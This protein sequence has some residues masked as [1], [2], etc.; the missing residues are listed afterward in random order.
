MCHVDGFDHFSFR[1]FIG[2]G[3]DHDDLF[4]GGRHC[5]VQIA[6]LP[7]LLGR[8]ENEF[9]VNQA[10][11]C[12]CAGSGKRNVGN[13]GCDSGT[14]HSH[15]LGA[16]GR[17]YGK[18]QV[19]Q[20]YIISVILREQRAHGTV[21]NTARQNGVLAGLSLSFIEAS[22]NLSYGIQ[23]F[24]IFNAQREEINSFSGLLTRRSCG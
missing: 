24:F 7:L 9:S 10:Y 20:G 21:D 19:I 18:H 15:Q 3:F 2:S 14:K 12:H 22:G 4:T 5:Q 13:A 11:L 1:D 8:I 16:A 17:I 6:V 23:L